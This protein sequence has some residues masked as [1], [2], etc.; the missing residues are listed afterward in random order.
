VR[1]AVANASDHEKMIFVE[2]IPNEV[3]LRLSSPRF[4]SHDRP[5]NIIALPA[6]VDTR[7][8]TSQHGICSA[9]VGDTSPPTSVLL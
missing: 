5:A 1:G 7:T 2:P 3:R 4:R 8:S 6:L 9:L